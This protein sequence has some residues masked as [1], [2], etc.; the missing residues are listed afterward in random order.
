MRAFLNKSLLRT[1]TCKSPIDVLRHQF[2]A[3][4]RLLVLLLLAAPPASANLIVNPGFE[5]PETTWGGAYP[6][7]VGEWEGDVSQIVG[8]EG[9]VTPLEG[10]SMLSF[11]ATGF[12]SSGFSSASQVYQLI[13]VSSMSSSID[14]GLVTATASVFYNRVAGDAYT[15]T[16]FTMAF[17]AFS[18]SP[19]TFTSGST[20]F[21]YYWGNIVW[22]D[23][24]V[25]TWEESTVDYL[26]P[27]GT[28]YLAI[29]LL[30]EE[31]VL[32]Q[33]GYPEFDGHYADNVSV[34]LATIP[35]PGTASL[36]GLGLLGLLGIGRKPKKA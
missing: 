20:G 23:S 36:L 34:T 33:T 4:L 16:R 7:V 22:S 31:D 1:V 27:V 29:Q 14:A 9:G 21:G 8:A 30:A 26:L 28:D 12:T 6:T 13:D 17:G 3:P 24:D 5:T 11:D 10:S 35:E 15:D 32:N 18:G 19:A 25:S 2:R